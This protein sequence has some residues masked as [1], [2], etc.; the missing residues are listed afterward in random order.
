MNL[1]EIKYNWWRNGF[2]NQHKLREVEKWIGDCFSYKQI[3][4]GNIKNGEGDIVVIGLGKNDYIDFEEY[5]G[6]THSVDRIE[7]NGIYTNIYWSKKFFRFLL[8]EI[9]K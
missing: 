8:E 7:T 9:T 2:V 4:L 1:A 6:Y 5:M 3:K